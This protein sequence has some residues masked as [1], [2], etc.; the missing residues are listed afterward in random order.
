MYYPVN[1]FVFFKSYKNN[2]F[3]GFIFYLRL[4]IVSFLFYLNPGYLNDIHVR[5]KTIEL[6]VGQI[7]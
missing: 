6:E 7:L 4:F 1:F 3:N 2:I 5:S